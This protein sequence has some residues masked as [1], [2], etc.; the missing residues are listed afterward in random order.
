MIVLESSILGGTSTVTGLAMGYALS[1]ILINVINKQSF[2]W[3]IAFHTPAALI[4]TSLAITF[5]ASVL[6][7]LVP[8]RL[9]SRIDL[10]SAIKT[11]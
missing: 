1:W 4:A 8:A 11:E 2:G 7:G 5:A 9:A 3:T 10:A 6:A